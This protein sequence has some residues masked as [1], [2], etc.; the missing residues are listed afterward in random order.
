MRTRRAWHAK[1]EIPL[2]F[3]NGEAREGLASEATAEITSDDASMLDAR[4]IECCEELSPQ[5]GPRASGAW[6]HARVLLDG[7]L[8]REVAD[9]TASTQAP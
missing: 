3:I 6:L 4:Q 9:L 5:D 7:H 8:G 1:V 2:E